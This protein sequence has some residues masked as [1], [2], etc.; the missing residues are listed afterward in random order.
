VLIIEVL[1]VL[2][3]QPSSSLEHLL[4]ERT[5]GFPLN[6]SPELG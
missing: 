1:R 4:L 3:K 5:F 2:Q 6:I